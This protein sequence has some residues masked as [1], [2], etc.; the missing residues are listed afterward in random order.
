MQHGIRYA[1]KYILLLLFLI[2]FGYML[3]LHTS[4]SRS[5]A[6]VIYYPE[7]NTL[8]Y[9]TLT[10]MRE[11]MDETT[12]GAAENLSYTAVETVE[13]QTFSNEALERSA[14]G[15]LFLINGSSSNL[16]S[17]TAELMEDD[18]TGCLLSTEAAWELF[19][20]TEVA[21]G[22]VICGGVSC[23][24]R[25]VYED[26][27]CVVILQAEALIRAVSASYESGG[28]VRSDDSTGDNSGNTGFE[29]AGSL[30]NDSTDAS[31]AGGTDIAGL[32]ADGTDIASELYFDRLIVMPDDNLSE[33]ERS[34]AV[35]L[36]ETENG[37]DSDSATDCMIYQRLS[38]VFVMLIPAILMLCVLGRG[39]AGLVRNRRRPFRLA[40]LSVI[41]I[42]VFFVFFCFFQI[43]PSI[44]AD[45]IPNTWS[46]FDFWKEKLVEFATC[47]RLLLFQNKSEIELNY[48]R[49]L[50]RL[51]ALTGIG[52]ILLV[53]TNLGFTADFKL[54]RQQGTKIGQISR[55]QNADD[56]LKQFY[57][58]EDL[59]NNS[60]PIFFS[61][62]ESTWNRPW[63]IFWN[64]IGI[65]ITEM[66]AIFL[67]YR[68]EIYLD[69]KRMLLYL[70]PY[71]L[72]VKYAVTFA[73]D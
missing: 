52:V 50:V 41:L 63:S 2:C 56:G 57:G 7:E 28:N 20:E 13:N 18:L 49:P 15:T 71:F 42:A 55:K 72:L 3:S 6:P 62:W 24:V 68:W 53:L 16:V 38:T 61:R 14:T 64:I 45:L 25:G 66:I 32:L 9:D 21:G 37:L 65:V 43:S 8:S 33:A 73:A 44:P 5:G 34:E 69:E 67:L 27:E 30:D 22:E 10:S 54:E 11:D 1:G 17:A 51:A 46:D 36:F 39:I 59:Q 31:G 26:T 47:I 48:Y 29:E 58:R 70:W 60:Q 35:E 4:L 23:E 12:A 19:G 40:L